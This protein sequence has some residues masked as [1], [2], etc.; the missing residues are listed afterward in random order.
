M[1]YKSDQ[2]E[3]AKIWASMTDVELEKVAKDY[4]WLAENSPLAH[5]DRRDQIFE[6]CERR[7]RSDMVE[8]ARTYAITAAASG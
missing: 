6:E 7:E 3:W 4:A 2:K 5:T 8:R 1:L